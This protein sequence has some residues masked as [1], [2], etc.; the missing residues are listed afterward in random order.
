MARAANGVIMVTTK[1]GQKGS[2]K[3]NYSFTGGISNPWKHRDV[4][5]ATE[6]AV[7]MNEGLVNSGQ[8]ILYEDP[9]LSERAQIGRMSFSTPTPQA[10]AT[11]SA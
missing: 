2:V 1:G 3:V 4:L 7:M 8:A 11:S 6:Y 10:K 5:N 9:T